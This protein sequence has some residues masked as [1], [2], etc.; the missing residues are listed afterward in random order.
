MCSLDNLRWLRKVSK[1]ITNTK[2]FLFIN[3]FKENNPLGKRTIT[4]SLV[5][6][7]HV[8]CMKEKNQRLEEVLSIGHLCTLGM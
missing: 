5:S 7:T 1:P 3:L 8:L 6:L 2:E 4:Y